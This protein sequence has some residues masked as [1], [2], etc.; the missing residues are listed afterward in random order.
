M[1]ALIP[2]EN[3]T[4]K[5]YFL[6]GKKVM[7]DKDLA[8]LYGVEV[9]TLKQAVRRNIERFPEDF[10]FE[11]TKDE[12]ESLRSQFVIL[13]GKG[14]Y[15]KYLPFAFTEQGVAMLSSVL[16]S[17]RAIQVNIEIMR[18]FTKLREMLA[19]H[20]ELK[21]KLEEMESKYDKQFGIVFEAIRQ[22]LE[23]DSKPKR[24]IGF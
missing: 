11:L 14:K 2:I 23:A 12:F 10:M 16:R 21:K 5:I 1:G 3:I 20:K 24:K 22:L 6:R 4:G 19:G 8:E 7:L 13:E 18:A 17:E 9:R 15:S